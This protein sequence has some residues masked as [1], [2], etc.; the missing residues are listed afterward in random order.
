MH[1]PTKLRMPWNRTMPVSAEI[2]T[3]LVL[4]LEETI[5]DTQSFIKYWF[6]SRFSLRLS[7]NYCYR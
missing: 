1:W 6:N 2:A 5:G 3:G 7:F 4:R